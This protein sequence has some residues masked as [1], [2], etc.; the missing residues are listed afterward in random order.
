MN[1]STLT[2]GDAGQFAITQGG[3]PFT[4]GPGATRNLDV[5]FTPTSGGLKSATLRLTSTDTDESPLDVA[6]SGTGTTAPEID[7]VPASHNYGTTLIGATSS[8][9]FGIRNI[10]NA[11]LQVTSV[12]LVGGQAGEFAITLGGGAFT[13]APGATH[14]I[15]VGFAP[16]STGPKST[17]LQLN[18]NDSDENPINV[19]LNGTGNTPSD[20][21]VAPNSHNYGGVLVGS[22]AL[23]TFVVSNTGGADLQVTATSLVGGQAGE[24]AITAGGGSFT[25]ASGATRNLEVRFSPTSGGSKATTLRLT[26]NDPDESP[27]DVALSGTA[28]TAPEID[29]VPTSHGYGLVVLNTTSSRT[30]A[31]RN[32]GSANLQVTSATLVGAEAGEFAITPAGA[33][34]T[35][36]PGATHNLDVGFTP[37]STG[38]KATTLRLTSDDQDE[39]VVDVALSGTGTVLVPEISVTPTSHNYGTQGVGTSVTQSFTVSNTGTGD[40]VVGGSTLTGPDASE[41]AFVSGQAGFTIAPGASNVVQVRFSPTTQVAK[42]ATLTIPSNDT[43]ENP[44]VVALSGTGGPATPPTF[45]DV[46]QGGSANLGTVST[47][48]AVTGVTGHLYL[49]AI[50]AKTHRQVT[51][52]TGLGLDLDASGSAVR[53]TQSDRTR[54][55][56]GTGSRHNRHRHGARWRRYLQT[57]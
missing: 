52:V 55:L 1:A 9:T 27:L 42:S 26:S 18:S 23:R 20:I 11:E 13:V 34:F 33:P 41:F 37:T 48:T 32:L 36:A 5:R 7:V 39:P 6:L 15:D 17:T 44:V 29:V 8:Q 19:S 47:A 22:N 4:L 50:S 25:L 10:G 54:A 30:F 56:V 14:N 28:T 40:L 21:D 35:V 49:A 16:T 51:A 2:G 38:P 24:F 53:R 46:R 3:A 31:I 45:V 43:D 57:R 12:T